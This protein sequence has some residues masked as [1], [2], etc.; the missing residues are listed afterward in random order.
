MGQYSQ[1]GLW[2]KESK[3]EGKKKGR[4]KE[5][6]GKGKEISRKINW[7]KEENVDFN[8]FNHFTHSKAKKPRRRKKWKKNKKTLL[9]KKKSKR[10]YFKETEDVDWHCIKKIKIIIDRKA[11]KRNKVPQMRT[12]EEEIIR[13]YNYI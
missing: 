6:T 10:K 11:R 7:K 1:W 2:K 5:K 4:R 12:V 8:I 3:T 13:T 9:R